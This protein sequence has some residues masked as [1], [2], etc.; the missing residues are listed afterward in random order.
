MTGAHQGVQQIV[1]R[2]IKI[3]DRARQLRALQAVNLFFVANDGNVSREQFQSFTQSLR[4]RYP[5]IAAFASAR[6]VAIGERLARE[7]ARVAPLLAEAI[8]LTSAA[9]DSTRRI[10]SN[11]RPQVLQSAGYARACARARRSAA[12]RQPTRQ[13]QDA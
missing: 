10:V 13:R 9:I 2:R 6:L 7:P 5:H 4:A 12:H 11:L 8:D 1:G 3:A